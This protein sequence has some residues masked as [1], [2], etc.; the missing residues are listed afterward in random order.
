[1]LLNSES[2][3]DACRQARDLLSQ[4]DDIRNACISKT[5]YQAISIK[6]QEAS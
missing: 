2:S 5:K 3:K 6:S 4:P 1:M